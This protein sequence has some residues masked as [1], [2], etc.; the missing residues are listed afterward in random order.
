MSFVSPK[1]KVGDTVSW[2]GDF[3]TAP[4]VDAKVVGIE[5]TKGGKYGDRVD[6]IEWKKVYG[7]NVVVDLDN[8]TWAYA[9]Q[10]TRKK[11]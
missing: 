11:D 1:L 9:S 4:A 7:R 5:Y 8:D 6:E 2:K 10:I 3:G